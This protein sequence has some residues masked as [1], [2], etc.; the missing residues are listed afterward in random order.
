MHVLQEPA[1]CV[2]GHANFHPGFP[3]EDT[4]P[5]LGSTEKDKSSGSY[6]VTIVTTTTT[7]KIKV[8]VC[9]HDKKK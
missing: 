9:I 6:I 3:K 1:V 8:L 2:D 4:G 7:A 5:M